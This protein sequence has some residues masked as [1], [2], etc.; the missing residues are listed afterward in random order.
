LTAT[1]CVFCACGEEFS[2]V[3]VQDRSVYTWGL[4]I[5]G[6]MGDGNTED[7]AFPTKVVGLEGLSVNTLSCSQT[8]VI[9][10]TLNGDIYSWG[11]P[12]S[13]A[14]RLQ[15]QH[16]LIG[17]DEKSYRDSLEAFIIKKP[18]RI[19]SSN[20]HNGIIKQITCGRMH[21]GAICSVASGAYSFVK[22]GLSAFPSTLKVQAGRPFSFTIQSA[23]EDSFLSVGGD[24]IDYN[25]VPDNVAYEK[26]LAKLNLANYKAFEILDNFDGS[27]TAKGYLPL[28]G[29]YS[30]EIGVN[31]TVTR[32]S[33]FRISVEASEIY[34]P[35]C[36]CWFGIYAK[37]SK[38][39]LHLSIDD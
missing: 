39:L 21:Y 14:K 3:I 31:G 20:K 9:A 36:F 10:V 2:V 15:Q 35:K 18:I 4:G 25:L 37:V 16:Q 29:D 33:P 28:S 17:G 32:D 13:A 34:P 11:L 1:Q 7:R 23:N 26:Q 12:G 38:R 19:N 6:Q 22:S 24:D 8:Q 27:Y 30:L 5:A